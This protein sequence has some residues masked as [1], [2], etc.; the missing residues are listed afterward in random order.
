[1][2]KSN[3][4]ITKELHFNI[5]HYFRYHIVIMN[6]IPIYMEQTHSSAPIFHDISAVRRRLASPTLSCI[7]RLRRRPSCRPPGRGRG[8]PP[9]GQIYMTIQ[10][11]GRGNAHA[12]A[13]ESRPAPNT[14]AAEAP[15]AQIRRYALQRFLAERQINAAE[16]A[17]RI[18]MPTANAFYNHLAGRSGSLSHDV[19][20][21]ILHAFPD[22]TLADITG[23]RGA[24]SAAVPVSASPGARLGSPYMVP[25][26]AVTGGCLS[27]D[28]A[29][30]GIPDMQVP[31]PPGTVP[32]GLDLFAI[33]VAAPG[34]EH[35][36]ALGSLLVCQRLI[37]GVED[38]PDGTLVV[39]RARSNGG[40]RVDVREAEHVNGRLWL[41][42][43]ST[44]PDMQ[45]PLPAPLPL[46]AP[47]RVAGGEIVTVLGIVVA[48]WQPEAPKAPI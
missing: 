9:Y 34:A 1:M 14:P 24:R 8:G 41:W 27:S 47:T 5:N 23:I 19:I 13:G 15:Q 18:G 11:N 39:L 35:L 7:R 30:A 6:A 32:P 20:E 44:D 3:S 28:E 36:F 45:Q 2:T 40:T 37:D 16:L 10:S 21:R 48:S 33:K 25:L 43:R 26:V 42:L 17:R 22:A 12:P 46:T 38:L 4:H 29:A 31:V